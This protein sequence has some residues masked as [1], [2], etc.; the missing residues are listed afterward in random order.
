MLRN[1]FYASKSRAKY[2]YCGI[3]IVIF[4]QTLAYIIGYADLV[5]TSSFQVYLLARETDNPQMQATW[6][7]LA[8]GGPTTATMIINFLNASTILTTVSA[9]LATTIKLCK[10][11]HSLGNKYFLAF[12]VRHY[13]LIIVF[14]VK[15]L[16]IT[17]VLRILPI[18]MDI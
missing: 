6:E 15:Y 14:L 18:F 8:S 11:C 17:V 4:I 12:M 5:K 1:P 7:E 9:F 3:T 10:N 2:Y 16:T 13:M